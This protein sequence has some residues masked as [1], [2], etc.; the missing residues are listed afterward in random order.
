M[1]IQRIY[2]L[3][4]CGIFRDFTWPNDLLD[5]GR[6]NVIYGWNGTGKTTLSRL[7]RDL[8]LRRKPT[9]G[10]VIIRISGASRGWDIRGEEFPQQTLQVRVFNRDFVNEIV[11]PVE[12]KEL[13]PIFVFGKESVEKQKEVERLKIELAAKEGEL[14]AAH[15][16]K[17]RAEKDL[18]K[19]CIS[20][21]T[22]IRE[23]LRS[24]GANRYNNYDKRDYKNDANNMA[25]S[26][27]ANAS[28]LTDVERQKL[29]N[30]HQATPKP[31]LGEWP[32]RLPAL[33]ELANAAAELLRTTVVTATI[34]SL[35]NDAELSE[36]TRE[37]LHL[38]KKREV[39]TCL[40][41]E[42]PLPADRLAMLEAHFSAEYE[43][44][45]QRLDEQ[46][47]K[48]KVV[49]KEALDF[50]RKLPRRGELYEDLSNEYETAE[51][52]L[53]Q[54][55]QSVQQF[56]EELIRTLN[57]KRNKPFEPLTL[58]VEVPTVKAEAAEQLNQVIRKHNQ[59]CDDF[60]SRV[61]QARD[62]L[63]RGMVAESLDEFVRLRNALK[64]AENRV[65]TLKE[66]VRNLR[67]NIKQLEGE[68]IEHLRPAE[69]LNKD[70]RK[71]LGHDELRLKVKETGYE[72]IRNGQPAYSLSEG[73]TT[74]IALLY[75]LKSLRDRDFDLNHGVVVL[76]D[77]V[78]SLDA[79]ALYLAF[80]FIRERTKDAGQLFVFTHNFTF[81]RQ[82]R[83]WFHHLKGQGK[84]DPIQRPARFYML[85]CHIKD[86]QRCAKIRPLDPL[87]EQY[88]SE[89]HY[90]FSRIYRVALASTSTSSGLEENYV[91][92]N[93]ARRMLES[94]LAFRLPSVRGG[95]QKKME[96]IDYDGPTKA[97]ILRFLHTYSHS[98]AIGEPEQDLSHLSETGS[99]L[100]DLLELVKTLDKDHYAE[101]EKLV[102]KSN[103]VEEGG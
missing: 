82:V 12:R 36:W 94:F 100:K 81:F 58:S 73:E 41:C 25:A 44:F 39:N 46:I 9:N 51:R 34:E 97:R 31:Q 69:E 28:R 11:F 43:R 103:S 57:D 32:Y 2:R 84:Q 59:A 10:Q 6:F 48:L 71:Y 83:N 14:T 62:R 37:G 90:L 17:E 77:P 22:V 50:E 76:D 60:S 24:S 96:Q 40:F 45:M 89:Y 49:K 66:A 85:D 53:R 16:S 92:P 64:E 72:I 21:A 61:S 33:D 75:F 93:M 68:I 3:R 42:Q 54:T 27:D 29:I 20:R 13:P 79:N 15:Q 65:K 1:R 18:D 52:S 55:L 38:H 5:F 26:G 56:L 95:L 80:G 91:L 63:A 70:L 35:R 88:E 86:G 47:K 67:E 101:M 99:V 8:G 74:A 23:A 87:L 30:R 78:S 7:F 98:D 19:Y 102:N 4:D